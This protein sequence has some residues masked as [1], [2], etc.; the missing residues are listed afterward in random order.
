MP[1]HEKETGIAITS[2]LRLCELAG[3]TER[4]QEVWPFILRAFHY[5]RSLRDK[6]RDL[7]EGSP[8]YGL[9]PPTFGDG[10]IFGP[11]MELTT[12][13]WMLAGLKKAAETAQE[14]DLPGKE[15]ILDE[16]HS[17]RETLLA[18]IAANRRI[19]DT[20]LPYLPM[21]LK[22]EPT[23]Y[24]P[25]T[26]TWALAQAIAPG[27]VFA[28]GDKVVQEFL[29]GL[30]SID[31]RQGIPECT[32]WMN[33]DAV[34]TY[35][36]MFYAQVFLYAG[37]P[38]KAVDYLYAFVNH[39]SRGRCWREEQA[40]AGC[41]SDAVWGDM[42]HN[43]ASAELIRLVRH[44]L[45]LERLGNLELLAG[46]PAEW[47]PGEGE[48][49]YLEST[50]TR[51]GPVTLELRRVGQ[52]FHLRA[53]ATFRGSPE[54]TWLN[55]NGQRTRLAWGAGGVCEVTLPLW[56]ASGQTPPPRM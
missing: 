41:Q 8:V 25:W 42:P 3:D 50:P 2:L 21:S 27:E 33:R 12:P 23:G 17:L 6:A 52:G 43:W 26:G 4:V 13:L 22:Q 31:H 7:G 24:T 37:R 30:D 18:A 5:I 15:D 29:L 51:W 10:G 35:A 16:Y 56:Q 49:L 47:L 46:L 45:V 11:E 1:F 20:G 39:A 48:R 54:A 9:F 28:P 19:S 55:W 14:L 44:L 53:Q 38:D 34:W 40:I 36:A 32:G